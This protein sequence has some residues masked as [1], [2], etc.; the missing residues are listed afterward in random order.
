MMA[1]MIQVSPLYDG[2]E[3]IYIYANTGKERQETLDF[4]H[5]CDEEWKLGTIWVEAV[6]NHENRVGTTH[7]IISYDSAI[8]NTDP[9]IEGHPFYE[10]AKKYGVFNNNYPH[11]TREMKTAPIRSYLRSIGLSRGDYLEAWGIRADEPRRMAEREGVCYPLAELG[12]TERLIREY[13]DTQD[14]DLGIKQFEGNCDLCF[15]KSLRKRLTILRDNPN[16]ALDWA[17][18]EGIGD[19]RGGDRARFDRDGLSVGDLLEMSK[20]PTLERAVDAHD[21]SITEPELF[22]AAS[23]IN[24]DFETHCH[25]QR[26]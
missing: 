20:S 8:V 19:R 10:V 2:L 22:S 25:C 13:W 11:C 3:K 6:V 21:I 15:K 23:E 5:K 26:T 12:I 1:R 16:V 17:K 9:L 4:I 18:I 7:R 14:F 24:W